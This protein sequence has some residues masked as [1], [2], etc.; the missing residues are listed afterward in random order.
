MYSFNLHLHNALDKF[1]EQG[2]CV[3]HFCKDIFRVKLVNQG[4]SGHMAVS[5]TQGLICAYQFLDV[6]FQ[7]KGNIQALQN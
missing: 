7:L 6:G 2:I 4:N 5:S 1:A 3:L